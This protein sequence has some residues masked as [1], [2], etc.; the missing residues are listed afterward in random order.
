ML[1]YERIR[2]LGR[3]NGNVSF[4][5]DTMFQLDRRTYE[6]NQRPFLPRLLSLARRKIKEN[7][8]FIEI[9]EEGDIALVAEIESMTRPELQFEEWHVL[10]RNKKKAYMAG[11]HKWLPITIES[12]SELYEALLSRTPCDIK[13]SMDTGEGWKIETCWVLADG[14]SEGKFE[15]YYRNAFWTPATQKIAAEGGLAEGESG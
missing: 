1:V 11:P 4:G 3:G 13:L 8:M 15:V 14:Y 9:K 12:S 7:K 10:G 6:T 5:K 2:R